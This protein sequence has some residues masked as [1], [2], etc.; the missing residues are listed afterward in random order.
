MSH[1][2]PPVGRIFDLQRF[3]IHDGP[4]I[5][6]TVFLKGCPMRCRWC[7][8]PESISS[9]RQLSF[10]PE[11]CIGCGYCLKACPNRLHRMLD[12]RHE[13]DRSDCTACG[14][15]TSEC[16]AQALNIVG[17]DITVAEAM[18]EV[19]ADRPFYETSGGGMTLSGG[20]P[21]RQP[22]FAEAMFRV[23][24]AEGLH[25]CCDTSGF[26]SFAA[27]ERVLPFVDL[28]L[29]DIKDMDPRRHLENTG[30]DNALILNNL[31][32]LHG[33]A[34]VRLRIPLIPGYNDHPDHLAGLVEL[35]RSLPDLEGLEIMPYHKLGRGKL[36]R[37]GI[38]DQMPTEPEPPGDE[39][40]VR[41]IDALEQTGARV[42]NR[43]DRAC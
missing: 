37:F 42:H 4:G 41:W 3:S 5:R 38:E 33:V 25:S 21:L 23:A 34:S 16:Y 36:P 24:G 22:D 9:E 28:F 31:R 17:R 13:L 14:T 43:Q 7:H 20:E 15:C 10:V 6:T 29:F 2:N 30:V 11:K 26:V 8:N 35:A 1:T 40:L 18:E 19:L 32:R 27:F 39:Q 12:G